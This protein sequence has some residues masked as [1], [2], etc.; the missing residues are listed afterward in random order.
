MNNEEVK[1]VSVSACLASTTS[2]KISTEFGSESLH[3]NL[4]ANLFW[5]EL[6]TISTLQEAQIKLQFS[7]KKLI[8]LKNSH[9]E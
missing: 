4:S 3:Q 9:A 5:F 6:V 8:V 7:I 2:E 1:S